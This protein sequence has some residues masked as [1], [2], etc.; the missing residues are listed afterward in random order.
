MNNCQLKL[1][2]WVIF[3][4]LGRKLDYVFGKAKGR[5]HNLERSLSMLKALERIG[6]HDTF[7]SRL[8]LTEHFQPEKRLEN[9]R[10][11][12]IGKTFRKWED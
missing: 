8:Y 4:Q 9:R 5:Q 1:N 2:N 12:M 10:I 3:V 11:D 6:I 7:T